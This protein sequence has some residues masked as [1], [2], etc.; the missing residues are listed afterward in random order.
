MPKK[1]TNQQ[2]NA[3]VRLHSPDLGWR[4]HVDRTLEVRGPTDYDMWAVL[5]I[6][7]LR[8]MG[9]VQTPLV[10]GFLLEMLNR[11]PDE[12]RELIA[13]GVIGGWGMVIEETDEEH[14][15]AVRN[16]QRYEPIM[17]ERRTESGLILPDKAPTRPKLII[18]GQGKV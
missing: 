6:D 7:V 2:A 16:V 1:C 15:I 17:G 12:T 3:R 11:L 13:A 10:V 8:S 14:A 5:C 18:P 9:Y 4:R